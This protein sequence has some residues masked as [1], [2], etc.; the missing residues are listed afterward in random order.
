MN[1]VATYNMDVSLKSKFGEKKGVVMNVYAPMLLLGAMKDEPT[2][3]DH[4]KRNNIHEDA[5]DSMTYTALYKFKEFMEDDTMDIYIYAFTDTVNGN[6]VM[7]LNI[8]DEFYYTES[9]DN[10]DREKKILSSVLKILGFNI[11]NVNEAPDGLPDDYRDSISS[12]ES[13]FEEDN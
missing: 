6:E 8:G 7:M 3:R 13:L 1:E 12:L 5:I 2:V 10:I 9:K 11:Y 4:L